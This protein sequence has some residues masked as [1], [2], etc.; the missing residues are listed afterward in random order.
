MTARVTTT[1]AMR[2]DSLL[3]TNQPT[4]HGPASAPPTTAR[5]VLFPALT[6]HNSFDGRVCPRINL[7]VSVNCR[8][9]ICGC[10]CVFVFVF[11]V[12]G[13]QCPMQTRTRTS[14]KSGRSQRKSE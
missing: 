14:L 12:C 2:T 5:A 4:M 7:R 1:H 6:V 3:P 9:Y 10:V 8:V 13:M 11:C